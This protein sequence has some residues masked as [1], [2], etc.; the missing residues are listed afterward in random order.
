[1]PRMTEKYYCI[2]RRTV[3]GLRADLPIH[4]VSLAQSHIAVMRMLVA[5]FKAEIQLY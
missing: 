4:S 3:T 5:K 2:E 1:M